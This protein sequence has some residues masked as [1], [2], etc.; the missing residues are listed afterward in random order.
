MDCPIISLFNVLW[1]IA[2]YTV[3]V[4]GTCFCLTTIGLVVQAMF[5][6]YHRG[7]G[8]T[9]YIHRMDI[10]TIERHMSYEKAGRRQELKEWYLKEIEAIDVGVGHGCCGKAGEKL[11]R[12]DGTHGFVFVEKDVEKCAQAPCEKK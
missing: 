7:E 11:D 10:K 2:Y 9:R 4:S 3:L 6:M 5:E 8:F 12:K 1:S